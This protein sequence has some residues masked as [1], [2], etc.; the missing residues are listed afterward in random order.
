MVLEEVASTLFPEGL[1]A[2]R[3]IR[4]S[5][6]VTKQG[7][8]VLAVLDVTTAR[9]EDARSTAAEHSHVSIGAELPFGKSIAICLL[10]KLA[11]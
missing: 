9:P 3:R 1:G 5:P 7:L 6:D 11:W 2:A 8:T 4:V 10:D